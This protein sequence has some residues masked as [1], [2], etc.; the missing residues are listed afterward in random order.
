MIDNNVVKEVFPALIHLGKGYINRHDFTYE[1]PHL[2][3][4]KYANDYYQVML[5]IEMDYHLQEVIDPMKCAKLVLYR[6]FY[7]DS[8]TP[9]QQKQVSEIFNLCRTMDNLTLRKEI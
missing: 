2:D 4:Y 8:L 3:I 6:Q 1:D 9:A 7:L 5:G